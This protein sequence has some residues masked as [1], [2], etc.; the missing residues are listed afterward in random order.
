MR[1]Y[2]KIFRIATRS[3]RAKIH[4]INGERKVNRKLNPILFN[5]VN[6]RQ[7]NNLILVD[8]N[9]GSHQIDHV[10]IRENGIFCIETKSYIGWIFGDSKSEYWTQCLSKGRN[11]RFY[12]PV[13]QNRTHCYYVGKVL[14][15]KYK[16]NS[17]IVMANNNAN[18]IN[19]EN[20]INLSNLRTY[21]LNFDNG[22]SLSNDEMDYA[23]NKLL[24]ARSAMSDTEHIINVKIRQYE[25]NNTNMRPRCGGQLILRKGVNG[26]FYGCLNYPKCKFTRNID[27]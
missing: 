2:K 1:L 10:E 11:N 18:M 5:K 17:L 15:P 3:A 25:M 24:S 7:I 26:E 19:C 4:G 12:N 9:G 16:I 13:K 6:H 14:G 8:K 20:V 21:L 27:K 22:V 23:Y